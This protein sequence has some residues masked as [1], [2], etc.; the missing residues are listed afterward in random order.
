MQSPIA[1]VARSP[2]PASRSDPG[3]GVRSDR[4][5]SCFSSAGHDWIAD[6]TPDPARDVSGHHDPADHRSDH[7]AGWRRWILRPRSLVLSDPNGADTGSLSVPPSLNLGAAPHRGGEHAQHAGTF[8]LKHRKSACAVAEGR[9]GTPPTCG[10]CSA[11]AL[12][13]LTRRAE[14]FCFPFRLRLRT[15]ITQVGLP[16]LVTR[17]GRPRVTIPST[18][19]FS[20]PYA[21]AGAHAR[22]VNHDAAGQSR[23]YPQRCQWRYERQWTVSATATRSAAWLITRH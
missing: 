4:L 8:L 19:I 17:H 2:I 10:D 5:V 3:S 11:V 23:P 16:G 13:R 21:V 1:C 20:I 9:S 18:I 22:T 12:L 6:E 15:A 14:A 7:S